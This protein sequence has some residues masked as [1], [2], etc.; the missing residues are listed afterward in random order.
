MVK[1]KVKFLTRAF[2]QVRLP[3]SMLNNFKVKGKVN[4]EYEH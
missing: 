3:K 2:F 4:V 1:L